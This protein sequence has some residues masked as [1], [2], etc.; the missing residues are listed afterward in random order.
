MTLVYP[1]GEPICEIAPL[2]VTGPP[3]VFIDGYQY[4][5]SA[6]YNS[7]ICISPYSGLHGKFVDENAVLTFIRNEMARYATGRPLTRSER[8]A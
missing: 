1:D 8:S 5:W 2:P 7:F 4:Y 6:N 3:A